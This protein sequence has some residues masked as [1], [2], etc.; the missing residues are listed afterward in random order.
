MFPAMYGQ[1]HQSPPTSTKAVAIIGGGIAGLA[2]AH[3][4]AEIAPAARVTLFEAADRLGGV[5]QTEMHDGYLVERAADMFI[6]EPSSAA[7]LCQRVGLADD[8]VSTDDRFR[9]AFVVRRGQLVPVPAGFALMQPARVWPVVTT[10]VLSWRGKTRLA[11]EYFIPRRRTAAA[12]GT[13]STTAIAD[14]TLASF[15]RRRLGREA[16]ERLVQ[17]LVGGIY[18]ADPEKL[19]LA[20]TLPRFLEMERE[21]RSLIRAGWQQRKTRP[22]MQSGAPHQ[23]ASG[24]RYGLF[25][26]PRGGMATLVDAIRRRS[27]QVDFRLNSR[28]ERLERTA[29]ARWRVVSN[30]ANSDVPEFDAVLLAVPAQTAARLVAPHD[31]TLA[32][33]LRAI[34]YASIAVVSLGF[35]RSQ[36]AHPLDGFGF[37]VPIV[38]RRQILAGSFASVKFGGR[39][40]ADRVLIRVFIGGALQ[41]ELVN[42]DDAELAHL[43]REEL[44]QLL[45]ANGDPDLIAVARWQSAMPQ[46]HLGHLDRV[47]RIESGVMRLAGLQLA[48]NAYRGVGIAQCIHSGESAAARLA[49]E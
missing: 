14:E 35:R 46:Y 25:V 7:D 17:P 43:A 40:P 37:V 48:G 45:G 1:P 16:F 22:R 6:T 24:A 3:R 32:A 28:I 8:L 2:A 38:E 9:Q 29:D 30:T 41:P 12:T 44:R 33:D 20:A 49:G 27:Q 19:S 11:L 39:A 31:E 36:L 5:L 42:R 4:L 21:Y 26:A 15:A 10:P 13:I 34:E 47:A 23:P 18:T